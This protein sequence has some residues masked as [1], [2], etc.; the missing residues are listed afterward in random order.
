MKTAISI[1]DDIFEAA[2][3]AARELRISRSELY[4]RAVREFV[5][6]HSHANITRRL[7]RIYEDNAQAFALDNRLAEMQSR[8]I[9]RDKWK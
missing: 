9:E 8:S 1:Q 2:E 6:R 5:A 7:N 3:E 4:A